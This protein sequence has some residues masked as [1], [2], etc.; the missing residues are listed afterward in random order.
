[1]GDNDREH[2]SPGRDNGDRRVRSRVEDDAIDYRALFMEL[3]TR[4]QEAE[5]RAQE[6]ERQRIEA[7]RRAQEA[8]RRRNEEREEVEALAKG[9]YYTTISD[10]WDTGANGELNAKELEQLRR[11]SNLITE[12]RHTSTVEGD[13]GITF[14]DPYE[15]TLAGVDNKARYGRRDSRRQDSIVVR[16]TRLRHDLR[17]DQQEIR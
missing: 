14:I 16:D 11:G 8:E 15:L 4:V 13:G 3:D 10:L 5:R 1:M 6:A 12:C 9:T 17:I 2:V 7:E